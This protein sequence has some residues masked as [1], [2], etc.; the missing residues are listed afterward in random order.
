MLLGLGVAFMVIARLGLSPWD[1][2]HQGV[3]RHTGMQIGTAGIVVGLV[4]LGLWVPLRQRPGVGTLVNVVIVGVTIDGVLALAGEVHGAAAQWAF[5]V[6]GL[7]AIAAGT[8]LYVGA[9]LGPGPR[10]GLMTSM[11][12]RFGRSMGRVRT[13]IELAVLGLGWL[14]GGRVGPGTLVFAVAIGPLVQLFLGYLTLPIPTLTTPS[15]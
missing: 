1:V 12:A 7:V 10:D 2:L 5:L 14:L 6:A 9:G 13:A 8:G 11:S 4:V 15:E 3:A